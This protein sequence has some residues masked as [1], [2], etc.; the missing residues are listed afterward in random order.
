MNNILDEITYSDGRMDDVVKSLYTPA[1]LKLRARTYEG[2][3]KNLGKRRGVVSNASFRIP[4]AFM[5]VDLPSGDG[6]NG[7]SVI[8]Q[9]N[10]DNVKVEGQKKLKVSQSQVNGFIKSS[11]TLTE[12]VDM[13]PTPPFMDVPVKDENV[14]S[15]AVLDV[16]P[17]ENGSTLNVQASQQP[18]ADVS[19]SEPLINE[20]VTGASSV[21]PVENKEEI[22]KENMPVVN[23]QV[24]NKSQEV[25]NVTTAV[26]PLDV[27]REKVLSTPVEKET[28]TS[29]IVDRVEETDVFK[30]LEKATNEYTRVEEEFKKSSVALQNAQKDLEVSINS[31]EKIEDSLKKASAKIEERNASIDTAIK[32]K[33]DIEKQIREIEIK[34]KEKIRLVN[35]AKEQRL[36][37]KRDNE[38]QTSELMSEN[39]VYQEKIDAKNKEVTALE[40]E[41][42]K[43]KQRETDV[44]DA[45]RKAQE[46]YNSKLAVFEAI[47]LPDGIEYGEEKS[48]DDEGYSYQ[49]TM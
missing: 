31:Y 30:D 2:I 25:S 35:L 48:N 49:K 47:T 1:K 27:A 19:I 44:I 45:K 16:K 7:Y 12:S 29:D 6:G 10:L 40:L 39:R 5:P 36:K 46:S 38:K 18:I 24:E 14:S 15:E 4:N 33:E 9:V 41:D 8:N 28:P 20:P 26:D 23:N 11:A 42:E 13:V 21:S 3:N 37:E 32:E 34:T 43:L 17:L 22:V